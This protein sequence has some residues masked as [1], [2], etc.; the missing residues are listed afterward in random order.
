MDAG[1]K[2]RNNTETQGCV[3]EDGT[4][5][6]TAEEGFKSRGNHTA[7]PTPFLCHPSTGKIHQTGELG[8]QLPLRQNI[9]GNR[10]A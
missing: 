9:A 7:A 10:K 8:I 4:K 3:E 5:R 6:R 1:A 2:D